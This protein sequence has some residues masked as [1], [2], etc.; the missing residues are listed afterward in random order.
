[1]VA[2]KTVAKKT[3]K[4]EQTKLRIKAQCFESRT[5]DA[6]IKQIIDTAKK[7]DAEVIG[8]VPMPTRIKKYTVLRSS[9]VYKNAREQFE[10]RVHKRVIDIINPNSKVTEALTNLS[11]PSG[12]DLEVTML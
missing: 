9:F 6:S 7:Y 11:L 1:M 5:L 10:M 12:V 8:P 2:K 3:T 4:D